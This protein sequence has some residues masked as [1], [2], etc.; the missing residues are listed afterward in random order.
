M[1]YKIN[2]DGTVTR[3][4]VPKNGN[5]CS[6]WIIIAIIIGVICAIANSN[7]SNSNSEYDAVDSVL[8][9]TLYDYYCV[10]TLF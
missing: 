2:E 4:N 9:D 10:D 3:D 7:K 6:V 5:G 8:Y 1:S